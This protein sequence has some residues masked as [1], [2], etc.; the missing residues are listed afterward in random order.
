[1]ATEYIYG[2]MVE[3]IKENGKTIKWMD[4]VNFSGSMAVNILEITS[5][6]KNRDMENS[7]GQMAENIEESG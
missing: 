7:I 2:L 3:F 6:I 5:R 4:K 1:M